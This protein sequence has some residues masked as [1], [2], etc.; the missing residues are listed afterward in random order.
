MKQSRLMSF[1]ESTTSTLAGFGIS[2]AA[3]WFF[4]P[5][6]GVEITFA[7]NVVFAVI[8]TAISIAR[9]FLLRR[10]F[11]ALH[12]RR[13]LSPAMQAIIA[14]RFR[15]I[16]TEGWS[17][18]H[19]D[20]H[21]PGELAQAGAC[22]AIMARTW[23]KFPMSSRTSPPAAPGQWPWSLDW[24]KPQDFRRDLVRAGALILAEIERWDRNRKAG[25]REHRDFDHPRPPGAPPP[26]PPRGGSSIAAFPKPW[27]ADHVKPPREQGG[28]PQ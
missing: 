9:G 21:E 14:E 28:C 7:Q 10:L 4:L 27:S 23:W 6:L 16:E 2:L 3:Q 17:L 13:P 18:A 25:R 11:E 8:M 5:L 19:D 1:V 15:Q 24:W 22:Y 20:A 12:I 26:N